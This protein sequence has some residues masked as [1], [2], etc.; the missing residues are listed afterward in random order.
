MLPLTP[1]CATAAADVEQNAVSGALPTPQIV[2]LA[3][4]IYDP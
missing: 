2:L 4:P 1:A 3:A